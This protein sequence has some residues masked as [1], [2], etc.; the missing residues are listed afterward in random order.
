M[1]G[2][3]DLF[4]KKSIVKDSNLDTVPNPVPSIDGLPPIPTPVNS[5]SNNSIDSKN[6]LGNA[7]SVPLPSSVNNS[8]VQNSNENPLNDVDSV[9]QDT[10]IE[11][12]NV[13]STDIVSDKNTT[14]DTS[15]NFVVK[16]DSDTVSDSKMS[17]SLVDSIPKDELSESKE[18]LPTFDEVKNKEISLDDLDISELYI[19]KEHFVVLLNNLRKSN[20]EFDSLLSENPFF[21]K[22]TKFSSSLKTAAN[23]HSSMN[24]SLLFIEG[25]LVN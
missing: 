2:L 18:E 13:E 6:V 16:S 24:E 7:S 20:S 4:K 22:S 11:S 5:S 23:V 25:N 17:I 19:K 15:E 10:V 21:K 12:D 3:L 8:E 9:V 1:V 14:F